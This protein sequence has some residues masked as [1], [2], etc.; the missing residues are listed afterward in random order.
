M[1][2]HGQTCNAAVWSPW[3]GNCII[4]TFRKIN[5]ACCIIWCIAIQYCR[6]LHLKDSVSQ[7]T[8]WAWNIQTDPKHGRKN[9]TANENLRHA[10]NLP[11]SVLKHTCCSCGFSFLSVRCHAVDSKA[12]LPLLPTKTL[13]KHRRSKSVVQHIYCIWVPRKLQS[14]VWSSCLWTRQWGNFAVIE[15]LSGKARVPRS[16]VYNTKGECVHAVSKWR[17]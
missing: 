11:P 16:T 14:T 13:F 5:Y 4:T 8:L 17:A 7:E 9:T 1:C 2:L 3:L 15:I 6:T 10:E 12:F